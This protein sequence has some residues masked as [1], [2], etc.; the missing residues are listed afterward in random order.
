MV[1]SYYAA[2]GWTS[3]GLVPHAK[4]M[5]LEVEELAGSPAR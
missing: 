3:E 4:L 2:R 5:A 1:Q